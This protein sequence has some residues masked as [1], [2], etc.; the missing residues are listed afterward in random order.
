MPDNTVKTNSANARATLGQ[1]LPGTSIPTE[2]KVNYLSRN[3]S[4]AGFQHID[5]RQA[6]VFA[7]NRPNKMVRQRKEVIMFSP[8]RFPS[9]PGATGLPEIIGIVRQ[10]KKALEPAASPPP[11]R[12]PPIGYP[13]FQS[14]AYFPT[15]QRQHEPAPNPARLVETLKT[16]N[17]K[18]AN[19]GS[20][21]LHLPWPS[22][23][24]YEETLGAPKSVQRHTSIGWKEHPHH[25]LSS[26]SPTP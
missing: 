26:L 13:L 1:G 14:S 19:K 25:D 20:R 12:L 23:T 3:S 7:Q 10:R 5:C 17:Q 18:K 2:T 15:R 6:S 8:P 9:R 4:S 21:H 22:A 24:P 16:R 11:G